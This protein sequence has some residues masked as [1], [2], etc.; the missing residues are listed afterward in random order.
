M[1]VAHRGR[2]GAPTDVPFLLLF[3]LFSANVATDSPIAKSEGV[4][5]GIADV[6]PA[7]NRQRNA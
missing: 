1:G 6:R 7:Q 2:A 3:G 5:H 4:G